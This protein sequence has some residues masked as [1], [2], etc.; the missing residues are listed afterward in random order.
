MERG[1]TF[2]TSVFRLTWRTFRNVSCHRQLVYWEGMDR[3][4]DRQLSTE[5]R[6]FVSGM[7]LLLHLVTMTRCDEKAAARIKD[8]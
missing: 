5:R 1:A 6:C 4:S 2:P 3:L 8:L 7:G